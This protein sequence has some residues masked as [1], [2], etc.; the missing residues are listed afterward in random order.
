VT[1]AVANPEGE[2]TG[3]VLVKKYHVDKS[4]GFGAM[5]AVY[6]VSRVDDPTQ[7]LAVKVMHREHLA[8]PEILNRFLDEGRACERLVH[9]NIVRVMETLVAEDGS[10]F[11]VMELLSGVPLSDYTKNGGRV[12]WMQSVTILQGILA[13]LAGAHAQ[14]VIHRDLKPEN[15]F[16]ARDEQ[17]Q[18]HAKIL[19]F[20]I[21]KVMDAAGGMGHRTKTGAMLGTPAY[22][23]PEQIKNAKDVDVRADVWSAGVVLYEMVTGRP[24]FPAPTEYA[25]LSAVL[26]REPTPLAEVDKDIAHLQAFISR[27]LAKDREQRFATALDMARALAQAAGTRDA[28]APRLSTL[29]DVPSVF[30][31]RIS[32]TRANQVSRAP[33]SP[34]PVTPKGI[35]IIINQKGPSGTLASNTRPESEPPPAMKMPEIVVVNSGTLPSKDLPMIDPVTGAARDASAQQANGVPPWVVAVLVLVALAVGFAGGLAVH[36][37]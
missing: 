12:P 3:A 2:L 25:R 10:P 4:I 29:P 8:D 23:S 26:N 19:D 6:A 18:Y 36:A 16:L 1:T 9:P 7:K 32:S 5:G 20:G 14:G 28:P 15:V 21:A 31:P 17:G 27:A 37:K 11:I 33:M 35:E 24:A 13:G 30:G 22:M 34:P